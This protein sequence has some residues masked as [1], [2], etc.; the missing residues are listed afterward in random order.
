[1][2]Q[3]KFSR[4]LLTSALLL[5][6][7]VA[8]RAGDASAVVTG[9]VAFVP[10]REDAVPE[11]FRLDVHHFPFEMR[12]MT[13]DVTGVDVWDV[14][15][16]SPVESPVA[17][18]NT[19]HCEYF[20]PRGAGKRPAVIVLH[21]L[22]GD[23]P[24]SRLFCIALAQKGCPALFLKMPYYGPRRDPMVNRRM[25]SADPQE[26]FDGMRQAILDIRRATAWL[27]ARG[28]VDADRLGVFGISLGGITGAL[29]ITAEPR[30]TQAC[31]L[32]AGGDM[33]RVAVE[34]PEL[35]RL[36]QRWSEQGGDREA[37]LKVLNSIDPVTHAQYA[38]GKRIL[39]LNALDDEVIPR[40][41]TDA[42][43]QA[44]GEPEIV[45]YPG[46]HYSVIR[47]LPNAL[48]RAAQ[49]FAVADPPSASAD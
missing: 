21:I 35:E 16:P 1:M 18:N 37:F 47:F 5:G 44:F 7:A 22:G 34:S 2:T 48:E 30:L 4:I 19:V 41:C 15:F 36:R 39:M 40:A 10:V 38:R 17:V 49:F 26:T 27:G 3:P 6:S 42:L 25:I 32:L 28:E 8:A 20:Q 31:L 24:L 9:E 14:Q 33:A 46:G 45:W 23:F 12:P 13:S 11:I 43:W 29:A